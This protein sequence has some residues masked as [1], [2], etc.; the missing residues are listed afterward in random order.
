M[1]LALWSTVG[2]GLGVGISGEPDVSPE[3]IIR[4]PEWMVCGSSE[5]R[6]YSPVLEIARALSGCP[7]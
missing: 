2:L 5:L 6:E 4:K 1:S 7:E 3:E